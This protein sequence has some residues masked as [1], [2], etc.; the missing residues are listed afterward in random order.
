MAPSSQRNV[1]AAESRIQHLA[2]LAPALSDNLFRWYAHQGR[3]LPWRARWPELT[4]AYHVFLSELMLQQTVVATVIPYFLRFCERW[5]DVHALARAPLDDVLSE[6]AGLG[7]YARARNLHKAAQLISTDYNGIFPDDYKTL[8]T[9]PGIGPYTAGAIAAIAFDKPAIVIDG[10]IER[11]LMR[12]MGLK[13]QVAEV[14]PVLRVAYKQL[15]PATNRSDFPQALMDI[16]ASICLPRNPRCAHCPLK[17]QC[18]ADEDG[19]A[20]DIPVKPVKIEK[21][22]RAGAVYILTAQNG[23]VMMYHRPQRGLLGGMLSFPSA[24]WDKS[25][26]TI[27]KIAGLDDIVWQK[28]PRIIRHVFTHFTAEMSIY[29]ATAHPLFMPPEPYGW[30][31]PIADDWPRLMAKCFLDITL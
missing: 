12:L 30:H 2:E 9:L 24:G 21:P 15:I 29:S 8:Q 17:A 16:G 14:K 4:P 19:L 25:A 23:D 11:V 3:H 28:S 7:Y 26:L 13:V 27:P 20:A 10:N 31:R 18:R 1:N 6:W 5:P 22:V